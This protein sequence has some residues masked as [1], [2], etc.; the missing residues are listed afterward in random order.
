MGYN[1][2]KIFKEKDEIELINIYSGNSYLDYEASI[3]AGLELQIRNY[4]FGKIKKIHDQKIEELKMSIEEF[5]QL[6]YTKT[7]YFRN[8]IF[9]TIGLVA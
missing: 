2:E 7:K 6:K 9:N 4:D 1:W 3:Y 5:K 8:Q